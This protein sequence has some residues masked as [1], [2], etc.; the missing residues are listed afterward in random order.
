[1]KPFDYVRAEDH[2]AAQSGRIIAGGRTFWT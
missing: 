1:M 2:A